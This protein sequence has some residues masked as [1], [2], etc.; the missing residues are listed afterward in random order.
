MDYFELLNLIE[1][2]NNK[3]KF[4]QSQGFTSRNCQ[5]VNSLM[6]SRYRYTKQLE[7]KVKNNIENIIPWN[8]EQLDMTF[9]NQLGDL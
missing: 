2:T 9:W 6:K 7:K 3:I 5:I 1:R 4:L 8:G